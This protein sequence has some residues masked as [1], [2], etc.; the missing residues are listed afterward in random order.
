MKLTSR[1]ANFIFVAIIA[2]CMSGAMSLA[3]AFI[4]LGFSDM[5]V[6]V[7]LKNWVIGFVVTFP[8]ALVVVPLAR[9]IV[10]K[11]T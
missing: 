8:I 6:R 5:L 9:A 11:L 2:M 1:Q 7:W 10:R 4:Q 3:M